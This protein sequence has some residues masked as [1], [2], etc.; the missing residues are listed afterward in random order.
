MFLT[1]YYSLLAMSGVAGN[2]IVCITFS[3][4]KI[5]QTTTNPLIVN[6]AVADM[7][8]CFNL[9]FVITAANDITWFKIDVLC[10]LN[11]VINIAFV[12]ASLL[13]LTLISINRYFIIARKPDENIFTKQNLL[14]F[15]LGVWLFALAYSACPVMGWSEYIYTPSLLSCSQ[16]Y[17]QNASFAAVGIV[18]LWAIPFA[19]LCFCTW[20]ILMAVY[21]RRQ[22]VEGQISSSSRPHQRE[23]RV[24]LML[25]VVIITFFLLNAPFCVVH[26]IE[27]LSGHEV[28][29]WANYS[30][31]TLMIYMLNHVNNPVIYGLMNR[32]FRKAV[33]EF[34]CRTRRMS[35]IMPIH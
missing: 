16:N 31:S 25:I 26:T 22:R 19:I 6:L 7:L 32:N 33:S 27:A 24:T 34:F 15:V 20:K 12:G 13:S 10:Q 11:G 1:L 23:R 29:A 8:Q 3:S 21:I 4:R 5:H 9:I 18:T 35:S 28:E 17:K 14:L 30:T 2:L